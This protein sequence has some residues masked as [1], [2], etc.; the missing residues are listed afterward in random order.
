VAA[1]FEQRRERNRQDSNIDAPEPSG[2]PERFF[3]ANSFSI[4]L[5]VVELLRV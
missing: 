4:P 1:T 5:I 3:C 2:Y